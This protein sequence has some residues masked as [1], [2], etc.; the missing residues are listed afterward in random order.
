VLGSAP[1]AV[2]SSL[3]VNPSI[4]VPESAM[5]FHA[6]RA[7]GPGGQNVNKDASKVELR[8]DLDRIEGL[9]PMQ[10]A[11]LQALAAARL[12]AEGKLLVVSQLT[13]D[14]I[15]NLE[16]ARDK[17][18]ELVLAALVVPKP[19]R[20]TKPGRGA[21]MRRLDEKKKSGAQ[22]RERSRSSFPE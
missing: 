11:R 6:V 19:R 18:K 20:K 3:V 21:V 22:K 15:R 4:V 8:V 9:T 10:R 1:F 17:V 2:A 16:D 5:S 12:D 14:Q 13:R 7:G